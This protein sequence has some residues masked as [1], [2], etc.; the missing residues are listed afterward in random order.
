MWVNKMTR[1]NRLPAFAILFAC[2]CGLLVTVQSAYAQTTTMTSGVEYSGRL[3]PGDWRHFRIFVAD[4]DSE[5]KIILT[6][7]RR[8]N[9]D[10]YVRKGQQ[11]TLNDWDFRP[12][13]NG[14]REIVTVG[15]NTTPRLDTAWYYVSVRGRT[16]SPF[17][18]MAELRT[19]SSI[20]AG[21]GATPYQDGTAFRVWAPNADSVH[22]AGQFNGWSSTNAPLV[23]AVT[24]AVLTQTPVVLT[25]AVMLSTSFAAFARPPTVQT[26]VPET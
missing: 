18:L 16:I 22:V 4:W 5:L 17:R 21:M 26:P 23:T 14:L 19:T 1:I 20:H 7:G 13:L 3:A 12:Y 2:V 8:G 15:A 11:P 25:V 6:S 10:V 9:P 24:S